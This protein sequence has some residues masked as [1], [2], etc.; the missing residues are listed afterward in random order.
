MTKFTLT[1]QDQADD[2]NALVVDA[3]DKVVIALAGILAMVTILTVA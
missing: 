2:V 1:T 3:F